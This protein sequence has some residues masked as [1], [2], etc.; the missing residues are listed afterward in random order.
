MSGPFFARLRYNKTALQ[1]KSCCGHKKRETN[2]DRHKTGLRRQRDIEI[3]PG[4][5]V[6]LSG[7]QDCVYQL[8]SIP[9]ILGNTHH[10]L[11]AAVRQEHTFIRY[12]RN[13]LLT[14]P[15]SL[16]G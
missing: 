13:D 2:K 4:S 5:P 6:P 14:L 10:R 16:N 9:H 1:Y 11:L 12:S 15:L 3:K 7:I 8:P